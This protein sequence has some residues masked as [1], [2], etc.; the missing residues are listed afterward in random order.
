[1]NIKNPS[2]NIVSFVIKQRYENKKSQLFI[3]VNKSMFSVK[4][5][6]VSV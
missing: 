5:T 2:R 6:F 1:M 4:Y 3:N